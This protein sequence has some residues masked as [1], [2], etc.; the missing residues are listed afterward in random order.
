MRKLVVKLR[1]LM[2]HI[3]VVVLTSPFCSFAQTIHDAAINGDLTTIRTLVA[4]DPALV[5]AENEDDETPLFYAAY[6][7]HTDVVK[8][9]LDKGANPNAV[10]ATGETALH[11]A[12]YAGH[13][14]IVRMLVESEADVGAVNIEKNTPL[15]Y[16][17]LNGTTETARLLVKYGAELNA[18]NHYGYTP[19]DRAEVSGHE[20]M[21]AFFA[22]QG[23]T[24]IR[25]DDP[26]VL[27]LSQNVYR[28]LFPFGDASNIGVSVGGD[29]FLLVD[30]GFNQRAMGKLQ[31]VLS[32]LGS[33]PVKY[34]INTHLHRDHRACNGIANSDAVVIDFTKL[35]MLAA[36]GLLARIQEPIIGRTGKAFDVHY[37]LTFNGEEIRII[38]YPGIHTDEDMIVHF[39]SSDVVHMG[40]LLI[41]Q[42]FP[43]VRQK[44]DQY[45]LFLE[46]VV[47]VF[48]RTTRFISGHGRECVWDDV[49]D[50][51]AMLS[52]TAESIKKYLREGKGKKDIRADKA[53]EEFKSWGDL[54]PILNADYWMNAVCN[55][56]RE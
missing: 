14:E 23:G 2:L 43:S 16:A 32:G 51:H 35:D 10:S 31:T 28:I 15:H 13:N 9:L 12:A 48:P 56:Y 6:G 5:H 4:D 41:S 33:G 30:T 20:E 42:S 24:T 27:H 45:L 47:D 34:I 18:R 38:P 17:A 40:D 55:T 44:A 36:D 21:A 25:I 22:S 29:G 52:S 11:F 46:T 3:F 54:I 37:T 7:G 8:Y 1:L 39:T 53:L 50:Y 19:R 49:Q 26:E